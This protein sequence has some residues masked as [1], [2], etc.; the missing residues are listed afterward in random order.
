M[1]SGTPVQNNLQEL[2]SLLSFLLPSHSDEF[3][4]ICK[5]F[6]LNQ[7]N[8][9]IITYTKK[10]NIH[11]SNHFQILEPFILRRVKQEVLTDL[12]TKTQEVKKILMIPAQHTLYEEH[13]KRYDTQFTR[14]SS[15]SE[16]NDYDLVSLYID[17]RKIANHPLLVR[18]CLVIC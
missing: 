3:V 6:N 2:F 1:L 9:S 18:K 7:T 12:P 4:T 14:K 10:V 8:P 16:S 5:R 13:I 11:H 17:L 15:F